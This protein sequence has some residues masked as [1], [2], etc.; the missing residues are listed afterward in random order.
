MTNP[1]S[2]SPL[3]NPSS[4]TDTFRTQLP[5]KHRR[6]TA[7]ETSPSVPVWVYLWACCFSRRWDGHFSSARKDTRWPS[8]RLPLPLLLPTPCRCI[9][10]MDRWS[11]L[12]WQHSHKSSSPRNIRCRRGWKGSH[13]SNFFFLCFIHVSPLTAP[14]VIYLRLSSYLVDKVGHRLMYVVL[15]GYTLNL[16]E[17]YVITRNVAVSPPQW[18]DS[19]NGY[20]TILQSPVS[21]AVS[22]RVETTTKLAL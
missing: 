17:L 4:A 10:A 19:S 16:L 8:R 22:F 12:S 15:L 21:K 5:H 13:G 20:I 18:A 1:P 7:N 2:F 6:V 11:K 9:R 14:F 3:A